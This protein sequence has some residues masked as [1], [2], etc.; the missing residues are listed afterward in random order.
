MMIKLKPNVSASTAV[1]YLKGSS[2]K[3]I[4][5]EFPE[6]DESLWEMAFGQMNILLKLVVNI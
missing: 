6:L 5:K 2:S 1:Q 3:I 4:R